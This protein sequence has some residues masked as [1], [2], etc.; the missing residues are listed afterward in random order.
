M[1][2]NCL[3]RFLEWSRR[4]FPPED[5]E[6]HEPVSKMRAWLA[7]GFVLPWKLASPPLCD[8]CVSTHP[9]ILGALQCVGFLQHVLFSVHWIW[10]EIQVSHD[11][12][13]QARNLIATSRSISGVGSKPSDIW[14]GNEWRCDRKD[15]K[16]VPKSVSKTHHSKDSRT[17]SHQMQ[18]NSHPLSPPEVR[19]KGVFPT[20]PNTSGYLASSWTIMSHHMQDIARLMFLEWSRSHD[21]EVYA[22]NP[23]SISPD[24]SCWC[25]HCAYVDFVAITTTYLD[26]SWNERDSQR[27]FSPSHSWKR[28]FST[29]RTFLV[30]NDWK[31]CLF[32]K[33]QKFYIVG[34]PRYD[35]ILYYTILYYTILYYT[36]LYYTI[37]YYTILYYT[38]LYYTNS[39][40]Y[41]YYIYIIFILYLYYIYIIFILYFY[42]IYILLY[43]I[44]IIFIL[45]LY[46]IY[47][48]FL[49]YLHFII[50]YFIKLN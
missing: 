43:Y 9:W 48:V 34:I 16:I 37:L 2:S 23:H 49:L 28:Q 14:R 26:P 12:P 21:V 5:V 47:I 27:R 19:K 38:I 39:I 3:T 32:S 50:L 35:M 13:Y 36:I 8:G 1:A 29:E 6:A 44:Y 24:F 42:Y 11:G 25:K 31:F 18:G 41:L 40:L 20:F 22:V 45:Y 46:Y 10:N 4:P 7:K 33:R 30:W 15:C 17:I